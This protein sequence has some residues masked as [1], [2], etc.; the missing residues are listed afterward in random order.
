MTPI[1]LNFSFQVRKKLKR[2]QEIQ[3]G[4]EIQTLYSEINEIKCL[5]MSDGKT[6]PPS[7]YPENDKRL[8]GFIWRES[9]QPKTKEDIFKKKVK[10][11]KNTDKNTLL[12]AKE[13]ISGKKE[14]KLNP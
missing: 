9:E 10:T 14:I 7:M 4:D 5:N 1:D 2:L 8:K 12:G 13:I 11:N 3:T 6:Y